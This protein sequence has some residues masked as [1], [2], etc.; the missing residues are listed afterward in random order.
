MKA[1]IFGAGASAN[2]GYPLASELLYGLSAWL[3]RGDPA[4]HWVPWAR[5]RIVQVRETFGSLD[6]FEGVLGKLEQYGHQR[7]KPTGPVTYCQDPKDIMHDCMERLRGFDCGDPDVATEGFY[8][9]YL[10]SD[11][12]GAFREF[13]CQTEELRTQPNAYDS[14]ARRTTG[15]DSSIITFNYDIALERALAKAAKWDIGNGYGFSFL[16][17][18]PASE[19]TVY[20]LHGSVNWFK[21]PINDV[22]PPVIFPRDLSLLGYQD[23]V[24]P[25]VGGELMGVDNSGTFILPDPSKKFYWDP[26]WGPLWKAAAECLRAAGE[27]LIHGYSIPPADARAR[28]LLFDNIAKSAPIKIHCRSASDRIAEEFRSRGFTDV[29]P[30]P[31]V[32][33][34]AWVVSADQ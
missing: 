27:V 13:F 23:L 6:D 29:R 4:V 22:P 24:D 11:L 12:I 18:R 19:V 26:F 9:Q 17:N 32:D 1:Y 21:E 30:F 5:N 33:F 8:P 3:D 7:V 10:R 16:P 31:S 25:R 28:E 20:K 14:F 34:E 2:A 15:P